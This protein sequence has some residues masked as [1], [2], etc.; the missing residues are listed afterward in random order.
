MNMVL[1]DVQETVRDPATGQPTG[2]LRT[3]GLTVLRG[4]ALTVVN[5]VDGS[6]QIEKYVAA[7]LCSALDWAG[8]GGRGVLVRAG[9]LTGGFSQQPLCAGG[10]SAE[11]S[12]ERTASFACNGTESCSTCARRVG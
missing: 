9:M 10:V 3:L 12:A 6:E 7:L 1:D 5:P 8:Q 2:A 4:T 11:F